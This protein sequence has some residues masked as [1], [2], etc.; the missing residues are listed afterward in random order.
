MDAVEVG[1]LIKRTRTFAELR[2]RRSG[3]R[4]GFLL[5]RPLESD[6]IARSQRLSA[7]RWAHDVDLG[8]ADDV[9]EQLRD[10]LTEAYDSSPS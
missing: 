4:V 5:S 3:L 7:N 2:P 8:S 10:W 9:D 1:L 6:R